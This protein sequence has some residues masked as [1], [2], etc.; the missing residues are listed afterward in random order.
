M[1]F[2]S[3]YSDSSP[4]IY[5]RNSRKCTCPS[6]IQTLIVCQFSLTSDSLHLESSVCSLVVVVSYVI[7]MKSQYKSMYWS[8]MKA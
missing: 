1:K 7:L 6:S 4:L 8:S 5:L 2:L 3:L